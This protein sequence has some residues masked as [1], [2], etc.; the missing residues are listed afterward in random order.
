MAKVYIVHCIDTE[1]PL[2]ETLDATFDRL[3]HIFGIK[4][5]ATKENLKK[6]QKCQ[7]NLNG[8]EKEVAKT[9]DDF[10]VCTYGNF[11]EI[12]TMLKK[13]NCREFR[14]GLKD[15][16]KTGWK[17]SW[18]CM[19]HVGFW[20]DNPRMRIAGWHSIYDWYSQR[21]DLLSG[22]TIQWH[23]HPLPINGN[24]NASGLNYVASSN[25]F[26]ILARKIIDRM[27][28]PAV[29][30]PGFHV[31]RPDSHWLLEQW[32]PFDYANQ[33]IVSDMKT[34][35]RDAKNGRFGNWNG[36]TTS[37]EP[38]H[39][40][41]ADYR[42]AGN[43]KRIIA[44]CLNMNTRARNITEQDFEQAFSEA[45]AGK[46]QLVSFT[47]HDFRDIC[48]DVKLMRE[49]ILK[50]SERYLDVEFEFCNAVEGMRKY[51]GLEAKSCNL[52]LKLKP[53]EKRVIIQSD[54]NIFGV[55]PFF[56]LK[57]YGGR[58][59]WSNLDFVGE[60]E[61]CFSFDRD[62]AEWECVDKI[63]IAANSSSGVTDVIVADMKLESIEKKILN[64]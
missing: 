54:E 9:V 19:D 45:R 44:R 12:E 17:C 26:E 6:L 38:Y 11:N 60:Q 1:G 52:R 36:A 49:M 5:E 28:F 63:G 15:S 25:V 4:I 3:E 20:G 56:C 14:E 27:F 8:I 42:K 16:N 50:V 2:Y 64:I 13:L 51:L 46:N 43:C 30:R 35:Q 61:W 29:Y 34:E 41:F 33:A 24:Y 10:L 58:Y 22:D 47:D 62:T 39:P 32:I 57:L 40:D 48:F 18:F 59:I 21:I 53:K 23:Y 31:E 37:W 55:Q 7:Y